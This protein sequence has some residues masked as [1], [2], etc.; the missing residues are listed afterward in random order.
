MEDRS[1]PLSMESVAS[2]DMNTVLKGMDVEETSFI[3]R[4]LS[5]ILTQHHTTEPERP[6]SR[7]ENASVLILNTRQSVGMKVR[8]TGGS[9]LWERTVGLQTYSD[10]ELHL[11][12]CIFKISFL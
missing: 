4:T 3:E 2:L 6:G 5:L 10:C 12:K 9:F 11:F 1:A 7:G 8:Q